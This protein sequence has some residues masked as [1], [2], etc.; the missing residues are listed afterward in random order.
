MV[1]ICWTLS[2]E[3]GLSHTVFSHELQVSRKW[4]S[5]SRSSPV[6]V[7][8][9][10]QSPGFTATPC[11]V[12]KSVSP[13]HLFA[14]L[15]L[16]GRSTLAGN[17]GKT[18]VWVDK[19]WWAL[20][21][22]TTVSQNDVIHTKMAEWLAIYFKRYY[23]TSL[24]T[25]VHKYA[26]THLSASLVTQYHSSFL[27]KCIFNF[28]FQMLMLQSKRFYICLWLRTFQFWAECAIFSI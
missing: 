6:P 21:R 7:Q 24:T 16:D 4:S 10:V 13:H 14:V 12:C 9:R 27:N 22:E 20:F 18:G 1:D 28:S 15:G 11:S 19:W 3:V 17:W 26:Q 8:S 23:Q 5:K 25:Q 2:T